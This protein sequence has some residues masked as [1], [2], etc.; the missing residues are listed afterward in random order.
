[1]RS[2]D[3]AMHCR[4]DVGAIADIAR[5]QQLN[6]RAVQRRPAGMTVQLDLVCGTINIAEQPFRHDRV[7]LFEKIRAA[8]S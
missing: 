1:M 3:E 4:I 5:Y 6:P 2:R 7:S 8:I